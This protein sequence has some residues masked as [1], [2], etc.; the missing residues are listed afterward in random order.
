MQ[1]RKITQKKLK[2]VSARES[3]VTLFK[4]DLQNFN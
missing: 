4:S 3:D 1:D 2:N